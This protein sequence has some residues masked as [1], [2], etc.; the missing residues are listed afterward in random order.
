MKPSHQEAREWQLQTSHCP[1][2]PAQSPRAHEKDFAYFYCDT[3][4]FSPVFILPAPPLRAC[5]IDP[6]I[7]SG[8]LPLRPWT[9]QI[10]LQTLKT[11]SKE[12][13]WLPVSFLKS[14]SDVQRWEIN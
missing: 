14:H 8:K 5:V 13:S 1:S 6:S 11:S 4:Y 2:N 9:T 12:E 10:L 3:Q 7:D